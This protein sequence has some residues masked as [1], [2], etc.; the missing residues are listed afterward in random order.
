MHLVAIGGSDAG[1][2]AAL[3]GRGIDPHE[4]RWSWPTLPNFSICGIPYYISGEVAHWRNLAH[5]TL[6][7][8]KATGLRCPSTDSYEDVVPSVVGR[9][10][11]TGA[12]DDMLRSSWSGR[13]I[14]A[15]PPI[16]G[17]SSPRLGRVTACTATRWATP[18]SWCA[19]SRRINRHA[20]IV[21]AAT[22][23]SRWPKGWRPRDVC[24]ADRTTAEVLP[25]VDPSLG[26]LVNADLSTHGVDVK[27]N[28]TVNRI[29]RAPDGSAGRLD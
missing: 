7:D 26:A 19:H 13:A 16:E 9:R 6:D 1:I 23:G 28:T 27:T 25:T 11:E 3:G 2:R 18:S 8:F 5:R 12:E 10:R 17:L 20:V 21:G 4:V 22:S 29:A 24:G 14:E 15:R